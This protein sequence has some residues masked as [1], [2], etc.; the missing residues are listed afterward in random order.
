[1]SVSEHELNRY[2]S[3]QQRVLVKVLYERGPRLGQMYEGA[4]VHRL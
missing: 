3:E 4:L 1:M 2:S